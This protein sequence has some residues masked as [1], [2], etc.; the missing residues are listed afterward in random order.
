MSSELPET[1]G[2]FA[3]YVTQPDKR[4]VLIGRYEELVRGFAQLYDTLGVAYTIVPV[5]LTTQLLH[6][7]LEHA[8]T[9]CVRVS[10]DL[11]S[12]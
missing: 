9:A 7:W 5:T 1:T 6:D 2:Y 4:P 8:P 10:K 3:L 12:N 11:L